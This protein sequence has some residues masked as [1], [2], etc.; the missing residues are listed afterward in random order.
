MEGE[1]DNLMT[2]S[3]S[4]LASAMKFREFKELLLF[5]RLKVAG[6]NKKW[7]VCSQWGAKGK[8]T[9]TF[10]FGRVLGDVCET[11]KP[12]DINMTESIQ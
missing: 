8:L 4:R 10:L 12:S 5:P 2:N 7:R 9:P 3:G 11:S 6:G 1:S